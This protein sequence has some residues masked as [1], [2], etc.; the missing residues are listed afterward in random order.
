MTADGVRALL[1][2]GAGA[3]DPRVAG[4]AAYLGRGFDATRNPGE[5]L[6]IDEVRRGVVLLLLGVDRRARARHV[7]RDDPRWARALAAELLRRQ[8]AD[9]SWR[10]PASEMRE[11]DPIIATSF[12]VA[13]LALCRGVLTGERPAHAGWK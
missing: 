4:G 11:D 2:L 7:A 1:R 8:R 6:R 13:A 10:N 12:A 9:G 3:D 5:F